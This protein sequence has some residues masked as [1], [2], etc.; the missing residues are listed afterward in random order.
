MPYLGMYPTKISHTIPS[1]VSYQDLD[2]QYTQVGSLPKSL[3]TPYHRYIRYLDLN[4]SPYTC[5]TSTMRLII[6]VRAI[7][8][9]YAV[10]LRR[11]GYEELFG[12]NTVKARHTQVVLT[13]SEL[14]A[15]AVN[16]ATGTPR[17]L[18][19]AGRQVT[20]AQ[21]NEHYMPC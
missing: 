16:Q 2:Q 3:T 5:V 14:D 4:H 19:A 10:F 12:W 13:A 1:Y 7:G 18:T 11:R 20:T 8:E 9:I 15:M 6:Y 17:P 21:G